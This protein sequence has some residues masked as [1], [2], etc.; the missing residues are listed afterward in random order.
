QQRRKRWLSG[1]GIA[2]L[3]ASPPIGKYTELVGATHTIE[4]SVRHSRIG[5]ATCTC[6]KPTTS[7]PSSIGLSTSTGAV[8]ASCA[9]RQLRLDGWQPTTSTRAVTVQHRVGSV[10]AG[11]CVRSATSFLE[12]F[13][14]H[15]KR[16][17]RRPYIFVI[18]RRSSSF[19][20][21]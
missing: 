19:V 11:S 3:K 14:I 21:N 16:S 10:F 13:G 5:R 20:Y 6:G 7:P 8:R 12:G 4:G 2:K 1:A 18:P 15:R 9:Q 17:R